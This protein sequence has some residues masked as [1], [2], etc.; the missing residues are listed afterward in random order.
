[1]GITMD[2][3]IPFLKWALTSEGHD[4]HWQ[5]GVKV[6]KTGKLMGFIGAIPIQLSIHNEKVECAWANFL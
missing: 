2:Y 4:K 6:I 3:T 5:V 1:L